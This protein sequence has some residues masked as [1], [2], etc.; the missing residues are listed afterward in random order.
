MV[1]TIQIAQSILRDIEGKHDAYFRSID[2]GI[3][4]FVEFREV[5][6]WLTVDIINSLPKNIAL[7]IKRGFNII[8]GP[9]KN[10]QEASNIFHSIMKASVKT[11]NSSD[12]DICPQ[13]GAKGKLM[14]TKREGE[15]LIL[16]FICLNGHPFSK[17]KF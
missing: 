8:E 13:C 12:T 17:K 1:Q 4:Y 16:E 2:K 5:D 15:N 3:L 11:E 10:P 14:S 6:G 9:V 7:E